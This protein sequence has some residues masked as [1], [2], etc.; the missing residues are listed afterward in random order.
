MPQ[1][2]YT[3]EQL[4][5]LFERLLHMGARARQALVDSTQAMIVGDMQ[6]AVSVLDNDNTI[7]QL[8]N[9]IDESS[10]HILARNQPVARDL[11]FL[12]SVIRM[13]QEFERI[14]DESVTIAEQALLLDKSVSGLVRDEFTNLSARIIAQY[15]TA[16]SVLKM[17]DAE[18][19]YAASQFD[20]D[21][22]QMMVNVFQAIMQATQQGK[23]DLWESMHLTV[24]TRALDRVSRRVENIAEQVYFMLEGVSL[25]HHDKQQR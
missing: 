2:N 7:D 13:V 21:T 6:L 15:D 10:M 4:D 25:K 19:A 20:E 5:A 24:I 9:E 16:F 17:R 3:H 12:M 23:F 22:A 18:Q 1:A 11:R 8:E 14:G